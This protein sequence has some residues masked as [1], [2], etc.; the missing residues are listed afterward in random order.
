VPKR[1]VGI[2]KKSFKYRCLRDINSIRGFPTV[3]GG[4]PKKPPVG[5]CE[6]IGGGAKPSGLASTCIYGDGFGKDTPEYHTLS[7][8]KLCWCARAPPFL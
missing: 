1:G 5:A 8:Y 3:L 2:N 7:T 4:V 6:V